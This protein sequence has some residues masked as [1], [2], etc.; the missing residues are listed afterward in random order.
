MYDCFFITG[1]PNQIKLLFLI[2]VSDEMKQRIY[3]GIN[4]HFIS[5][6]QSLL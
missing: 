1:K 4:S 6:I 3:R 5:R 2:Y